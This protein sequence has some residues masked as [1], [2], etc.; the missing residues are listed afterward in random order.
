[1]L[2]GLRAKIQCDDLRR[3][4]AQAEWRQLEEARRTL[5]PLEDPLMPFLEDA[6]LVPRVDTIDE[7]G[8]ASE[9]FVAL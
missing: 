5:A 9:L 6:G 2:E 3:K 4:A 7:D 8:P 1:M